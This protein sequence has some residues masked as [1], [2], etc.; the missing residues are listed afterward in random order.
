MKYNFQKFSALLI[1]VF[2][3]VILSFN[4]VYA[5]VSPEE[6]YT[7]QGVVS[8]VNHNEGSVQIGEKIYFFEKNGD[9]QISENQISESDLVEIY[10]KKV[11]EKNIITLI[12][13]IQKAQ[14]DKKMNKKK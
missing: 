7:G 10:Y 4:L 8:Y 13:R 9:S 2:V 1:M 5:Y 3:Y 14:T 12:N 11:D 6:I